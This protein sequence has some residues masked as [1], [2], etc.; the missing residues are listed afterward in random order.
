MTTFRKA[1][2]VVLSFLF[3]EKP[4]T[5]QYV[6][7]GLIVM[8]GIGLNIYKKNKVVIDNWISNKLRRSKLFKQKSVA[9][10]VLLKV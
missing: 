5:I 7:S 8:L 2:T 10:Q 4:F 1:L 6:W 9:E 3:F